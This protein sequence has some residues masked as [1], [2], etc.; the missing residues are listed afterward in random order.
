MPRLSG[1]RVSRA[2]EMLAFR[3]IETTTIE[4]GPIDVHGKFLVGIVLQ[5]SPT[6][7]SSAS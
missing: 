2:L 6:D 1:S 5:F 4:G 7:Y 3:R